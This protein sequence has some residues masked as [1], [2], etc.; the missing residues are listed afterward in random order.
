MRR[1]HHHLTPKQ[2][3]YCPRCEQPILPHHVCSNC[4]FY[5]NREVV[6]KAEK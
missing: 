1:S 2:I 4:G 3:Q 5:Q 6:V